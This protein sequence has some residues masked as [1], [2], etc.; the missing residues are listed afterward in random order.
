MPWDAKHLRLGIKAAGIGLWSWNVDTDD[1]TLDER[2]F[3]LWGLP[4]SAMCVS[5]T[6]PATSIPQIAT[7]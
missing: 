5:K 4:A 1:L 2:A 3:D 7:G 6:F